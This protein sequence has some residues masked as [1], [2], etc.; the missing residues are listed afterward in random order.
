MGQTVRVNGASGRWLGWPALSITEMGLLL[1][2]ALAE[3]A[4][5]ALGA[6][7]IGGRCQ[8]T[9]ARVTRAGDH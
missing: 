6:D 1:V 9:V 2:L 7:S 4:M 3:V 8:W 5:L